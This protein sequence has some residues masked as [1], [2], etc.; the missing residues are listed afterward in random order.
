MSA[1]TDSQNDSSSTDDSDIH[2]HDRLYAVVVQ[3]ATEDGESNH[4]SP[5]VAEVAM[6]EEAANRYCN[7]HWDNEG[8]V[9]S[10]EVMPLEEADEDPDISRR[11]TRQHV[12]ISG[13]RHSTWY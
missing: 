12:N 10:I 3:W 4:H 9:E 2:P 1:E 11:S 13:D 6:G 8:P 7:I 5:H